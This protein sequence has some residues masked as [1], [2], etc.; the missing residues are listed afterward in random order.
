M[1]LFLKDQPIYFLEEMGTKIDLFTLDKHRLLHIHSAVGGTCTPF[2]P[3]LSNKPKQF[4]TYPSESWEPACPRA[5]TSIK[6][7]IARFR[8][9]HH[10]SPEASCKL[11]LLRSGPCAS[12][13]QCLQ[14]EP[15]Q[16]KKTYHIPPTG[17]VQ[18][19]SQS[20]ADSGIHKDF[21]SHLID[22]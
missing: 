2:H 3:W 17:G 14:G 20:K 6:G 12:G 19:S 10:S 1:I 5:D 18:G 15:S 7:S 16:L 21:I 13:K 11:W 4:C 22:M 8:D 9:P